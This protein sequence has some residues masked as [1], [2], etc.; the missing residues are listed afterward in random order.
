MSEQPAATPTAFVLLQ[1]RSTRLALGTLSPRCAVRPIKLQR[2]LS[3]TS[4]ANPH[5]HDH[6]S[7]AWV[8]TLPAPPRAALGC[9]AA[10]ARPDTTWPSRNVASVA[11]RPPLVRAP[12]F[13]HTTD[14]TSAGILRPSGDDDTLQARSPSPFRLRGAP[15][16]ESEALGAS[17]ALCPG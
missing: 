6:A 15:A 12:R 16:S 11:Q 14:L 7:K 5:H 13:F 4:N 2:C 10:I 9:S 3:T 1:S 17:E 8:A